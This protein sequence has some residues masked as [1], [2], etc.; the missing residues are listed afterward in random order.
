M[1]A[2]PTVEELG[3]PLPLDFIRPTKFNVHNI[4]RK[5][6]GNIW[7]VDYPRGAGM[8]IHDAGTVKSNKNG[9]SRFGGAETAAE[10]GGAAA[11]GI[12]RALDF[13]TGAT[14]EVQLVAA[15]TWFLRQAG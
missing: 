7:E 11:A 1:S 15:D 5:R 10:G 6:I 14:P 8:C 3:E 9:V 2:E 4:F 13:D 12:L